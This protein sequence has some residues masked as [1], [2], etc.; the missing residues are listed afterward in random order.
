MDCGVLYSP[1][2]ELVLVAETTQI[3]LGAVEDVLNYIA[4]KKQQ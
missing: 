3:D 2:R 1:R 4:K